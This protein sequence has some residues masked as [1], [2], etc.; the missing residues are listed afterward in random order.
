MRGQAAS[1]QRN[2]GTMNTP[3]LLTTSVIAVGLL[4]AA[5]QFQVRAGFIQDPSFETDYNPT[6]PHYGTVNAWAGLSGDNDVTGPFHNSVTAIPDQSQVGF[7]QGAGAVT[8]DISGLT[9]GEQYWLQFWYDARDSSIK[10]DITASFNGVD[11]DKV[12]NVQPAHL[13]NLP[14]YFASFPFTPDVDSGTLALTVAVTG[15]S[16]ALFDGVNI[17]QRDTNN[18]TVAKI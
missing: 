6:W 14:Y 7:K 1:R 17:V 12:V 15:D 18:V 9:P 11:I 2:V 10:V 5:T 4:A 13:K 16:T 8:Q 3:K